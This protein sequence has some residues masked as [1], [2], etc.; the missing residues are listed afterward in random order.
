MPN[1]K[2]YFKN[3]VLIG[4]GTYKFRPYTVLSATVPLTTN[5]IGCEETIPT[6]TINRLGETTLNITALIGYRLP[7]SVQVTGATAVSWNQNTGKL[8]VEKP[9]LDVVT[10]KVVCEEIR[11]SITTNLTNVIQTG[12]ASSVQHMDTATL[13]FAA[14]VNYELPDDI[15]VT[16]DTNWRWTQNSGEL[17][18]YDSKTPITVTIAGV[19]LLKVISAGEYTLKTEPTV[20]STHAQ[21]AFTTNGVTGNG[22]TVDATGITYNLAAPLGATKVYTA[23]T[24]TWTLPAYKTITLTAEAHVSEAFNAW[25]SANAAGGG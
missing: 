17:F 16:G 18:V 4:T 23:A 1:Y 21:F 3:N 14:D 20:T 12:G 11:H 25:W 9:T 15:T 6:R 8:V 7:T 5:F 10:I 19:Y 2:H 22:I 13:T 24:K